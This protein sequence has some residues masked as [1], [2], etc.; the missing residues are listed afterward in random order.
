L[1]HYNKTNCSVEE[2]IR[3]TANIKNVVK[4]YVKVFEVSTDN[5][6]RKNLQPFSTDINLDGLVP[7]DEK[8]YD[9]K[10][11]PSNLKHLEH[12]EFDQF[13]GRRGLFII[14]FIGNGISSR[15]VVQKGSLQIIQRQTIA[16]HF[17]FILNEK[18]E[19]CKGSYTGLWFDEEFFE[20]DKNGRVV[21]P[22]AR[23]TICKPAVI[24]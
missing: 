12:F 3:I 11:A 7:K 16:G 19:I 13:N 23:K 6:Y 9:F 14:E 10:D 18:K 8:E 17:L 20:A 22:Y 15:A 5:Y 21:I 1:V 24:M 4:L 2:S